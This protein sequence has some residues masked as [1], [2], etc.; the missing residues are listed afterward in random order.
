[1]LDNTLMKSKAEKN[2]KPKL[3]APEPKSITFDKGLFTAF[4][5]ALVLIVAFLAYSHYVSKPTGFEDV[6]QIMEELNGDECVKDS[7]CPQPRCPGVRSVCDDG[8]CYFMQAASPPVK[9]IDLRTPICGNGI[10]EDGERS[11]CEDDCEDLEVCN[12]DGE[13]E[14]N[15]KDKGYASNEDSINCPT[16]CSCG[17]GICDDY[18]RQEVGKTCAEDCIH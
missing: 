4:V 11:E 1:M 6:E 13:C 17:D 12:Y 18:E 15:L 3:T 9:C 5:A 16:D 10:C 2:K 14:I 7:D 8:Y